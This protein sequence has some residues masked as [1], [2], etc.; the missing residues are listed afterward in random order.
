VTNLALTGW[1]CY[2]SLQFHSIVSHYQLANLFTK[3]K[4]KKKLIGLF[5]PKI[6]IIIIIIIINKTKFGLFV[7]SLINTVTYQVFGYSC[8]LRI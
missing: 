4:K 1:G 2:S 7:V 8:V 5:V 6:I 3:K